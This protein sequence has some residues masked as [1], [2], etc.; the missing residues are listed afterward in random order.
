VAINPLV[1]KKLSYDFFRD[2]APVAS[3]V[4]VPLVMVVNP[5]LPARTVPEFIAYA[6][7]NPGKLS[8]ASAGLGTGMSALPP[9]ATVEQTL[10]RP[11]RR[12]T[13]LQQ[14][15]PP[16]IATTN[17]IL[18]HLKTIGSGCRSFSQ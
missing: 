10:R 5:L 14:P 3:M 4:R 13:K 8:S 16:R 7:A 2:T 15:S 1:Y 9:R 11:K 6:M 12:A 17:L 18:L